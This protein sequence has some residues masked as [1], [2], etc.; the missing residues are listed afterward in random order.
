MTS[1]VD[2]AIYDVPELEGTYDSLRRLNYGS[3]RVEDLREDALDPVVYGLFEDAEFDDHSIELTFEEFTE[4]MDDL[5]DTIEAAR[6][7]GW[8]R[9]FTD[10]VFQRGYDAI[11]TR[12]EEPDTDPGELYR[13]VQRGGRKALRAAGAVKGGPFIGLGAGYAVDPLL[14]APGALAGLFGGVGAVVNAQYRQQGRERRIE[15]ELS[16]TELEALADH[17]VRVRDRDGKTWSP[18]RYTSSS[19]EGRDWTQ[20]D[21]EEA[22]ERLQ[23]GEGSQ[24]G[25]DMRRDILGPF[26][27]VPAG[28]MDDEPELR[29][30][31]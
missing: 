3:A 15:E 29:C 21:V 30:G 1:R 13:E 23:E 25:E 9:A 27:E 20:E 10:A 28:T 14:A 4:Y 2:A 22:V 24:A 5:E 12:L 26:L 7:S 6:D 16:G 11:D 18:E 31:P 8:W 19:P 17:R